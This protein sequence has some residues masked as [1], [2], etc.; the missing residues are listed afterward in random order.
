MGCGAGTAALPIPYRRTV[1]PP[2][3]HDL[4]K[5]SLHHHTATTPCQSPA[6]ESWPWRACR[7]AS[8]NDASHS[9]R[10]HRHCRL[11]VRLCRSLPPPL[12]SLPPP[13]GDRRGPLR[14]GR[15]GAGSGAEGRQGAQG[16]RRR[17]CGGSSSGSSGGSGGS[18]GP[19]GAEPGNAVPL[20]LVRRAPYRPCW[21]GGQALRMGP[22]E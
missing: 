2:P 11:R 21:P 14:A 13:G 8:N 6:S 22:G 12:P 18:G 20:P 15:G 9:P 16:L 10:H 5:R 3:C 4:A 1:P 19:S 17:W 7:H